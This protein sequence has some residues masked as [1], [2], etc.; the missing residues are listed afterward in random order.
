MAKNT[1]FSN[2]LTKYE[3]LLWLKHFISQNKLILKVSLNKL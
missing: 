2:Y 3:I 1:T